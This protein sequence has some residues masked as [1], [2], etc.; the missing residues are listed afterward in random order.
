ML[1]AD[2]LGLGSPVAS[3]KIPKRLLK[4][5]T[6]KAGTATVGTA[7]YTYKLDSKNRITYAKAV[8]TIGGTV[9]KTY[10]YY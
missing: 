5:Q 7:T 1:A 6:I 3:S 4:K 8:S 9:I 2:P 10:T